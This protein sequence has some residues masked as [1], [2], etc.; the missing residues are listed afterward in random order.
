LRKANS[1]LSIQ[2]GDSLI[3]NSEQTANLFNTYFSQVGIELSD[4]IPQQNKQPFSYFTLHERSS[5][6]FRFFDTTPDEVNILVGKLPN[7]SAP[8]DK[9]PTFIFKKNSHLI[10]PVIC[11]LFNLSIRKE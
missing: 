11:E 3:T 4:K 7:K 2:D 1:D 10:S 8:L 9:I 5:N 6:S